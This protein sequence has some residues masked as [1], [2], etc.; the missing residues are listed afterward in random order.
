LVANGTGHYIVFDAKLKTIF[1]QGDV[2]KGKYNGECTGYDEK[3]KLKFAEKYENGKLITGTSTDSAGKQINYT[4]RSVSAE[5]KGGI[6]AFYSFLAHTIRYPG[7]E[8]ENNIQGTVILKF[9]I[10]KLGGVKDISFYRSVSANIDAEALRV[11]KLSSS[12]WI[13]GYYLG[14]PVSQVYTVPI[15]F[16]L[17]R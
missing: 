16:S 10:D 12:L 8:R 5:Y 1:E 11:I 7:P 6:D 2:L 14:K 3:F 4:A 9:V 13:P 17:G 15:S